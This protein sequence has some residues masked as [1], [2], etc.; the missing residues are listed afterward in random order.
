MA[1]SKQITPAIATATITVVDY[2]QLAGSTITVDATTYFEGV[3][4]DYLAATSNNATATSIAN[5]ITQFTATANQ[6]VVTLSADIIGPTGNANTLTTSDLVNL[7]PSGSTFSGGSSGTI[8]SSAG[9]IYAVA[10]TTGTQACDL[11]FYDGVDAATGTLKLRLS[12]DA[13]VNNY[14]KLSSGMIFPNGCFV[15][16]TQLDYSSIPSLLTVDYAKI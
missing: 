5:A 4:Q 3:G 12:C 9:T 13:N 14:F 15:D 7:R 2:T 6:N 8:V 11:D 16:I 1:G 10:C